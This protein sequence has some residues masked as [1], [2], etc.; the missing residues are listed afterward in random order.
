MVD[1]T[2][3]I[4]CPSDDYST[5]KERVSL[6]MIFLIPFIIGAV[7]ITALPGANYVVVGMG[8]ICAAGF[9]IGSLRGNIVFPPE[10]LLFSGFLVWS[11]LGLFVA[12]VHLLVIGRMFTLFQL[13]VMT[14]II[15]HFC[16]STKTARYLLLAVL[17][18][19]FIVGLS[20]YLSGEYERAE[21][22]GERAAGF[23][24][25]ANAFSMTLVYASAILFYFFKTWKSWI[26][27]AILAVSLV[28]IALL[29]I[30]SGSR[31]GFISFLVLSA[32]WFLFSYGREVQK[33]PVTVIIMLIVLLFG[34][35][36]LFSSLSD[37]TMGKRLD[38]MMNAFR[39]S[40]ASGGSLGLRQAMVGQG[41]A[42]IK[43]NPII[44]IG[45]DQFRV[46]S[47]TGTYSHNNYIEVFYSTG[48]PGGILYYSIFLV[49]W[50]RLRRLGKLLPDPKS[51]ELVSMAKA[52]IIMVLISD[53]AV[54]DYY[55][56]LHWIVMAILI[57]WSYHK[58]QQI[59]SLLATTKN[60]E[61]ESEAKTEYC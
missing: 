54:I 27:K 15:F 25:N 22:E 30:A 50:L 28:G 24:L 32:A 26:L 40:G 3:N 37:T 47:G 46:V 11:G 8:V 14:L 53:M 17:T 1:D 48:I 60:E 13:Y 10:A 16:T 5:A 59:Q 61:E 21:V 31:A 42:I 7:S 33:Q 51:K 2:N 36:I 43:K 49:L 44:G 18:G 38:E 6:F 41:I 34:L 12:Q 45:L 9:A 57:G 56:K 39:E 20:A 35:F 52:L 19:C 23:A 4:G 55:I 58:E 29:V